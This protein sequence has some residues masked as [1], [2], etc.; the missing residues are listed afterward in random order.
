MIRYLELMSRAG[1]KT[2]T[3]A[4]HSA[5]SSKYNCIK[6]AFETQSMIKIRHTDTREILEQ[7]EFRDER[8]EKERGKGEET[9]TGLGLL[10]R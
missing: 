7:K 6:E 8:R 2:Q 3:A 1:S 5:L 9:D 10:R 4:N